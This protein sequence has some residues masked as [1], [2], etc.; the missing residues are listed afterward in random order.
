MSTVFEKFDGGLGEVHMANARTIYSTLK[1]GPSDGR[2]VNE[3]EIPKRKL[4]F[5]EHLISWVSA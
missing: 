2:L 4:L 1:N 5:P 3:E